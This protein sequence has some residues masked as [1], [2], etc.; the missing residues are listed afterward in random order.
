MELAPAPVAL[1]LTPPGDDD[2]D[3][4]GR[5]RRRYGHPLLHRPGRSTVRRAGK[6]VLTYWFHLSREV[7]KLGE[8]KTAAAAAATR[9]DSLRCI[10][11]TGAAAVPDVAAAPS[12]RPQR[13]PDRISESSFLLNR[14]IFIL[15]SQGLGRPFSQLTRW[16]AR[17]KGAP[18]A[19]QPARLPS[20]LTDWLTG[21]LA[22]GLAGWLAGGL[23]ERAGQGG[24]LL[25]IH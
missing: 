3:E 19:A 22:G 5:T 1:L 23:S 25:G 11:V 12:S 15:D 9:V 20:R 6:T 18:Q 8:V 21:W 16:M 7:G 10:G 14:D 17:W 2:D 13:V 4:L 24:Q